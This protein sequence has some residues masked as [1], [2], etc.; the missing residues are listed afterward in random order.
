MMPG[1]ARIIGIG[2]A[3]AGDDAAGIAVLRYLRDWAP[4]EVELVE[5]AEPS[6]IIPLLADGA[7]RVVL[8]DAV[9]DAGA[10][11]RVITIDP[12]GAKMRGRLLS[13]HGVGLLEAIELARVLAPESIA[14]RIVIVGVTIERPAAYGE[15]LSAAVE[16]VVPRAADK[17]LRFAR[18]RADA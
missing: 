18:R 3:V 6:A 13:S 9:L 1:K 11:G 10:P 12:S 16:A 8:V 2:Q 7:K 17:A 5:A 4:S 14:P 15:R